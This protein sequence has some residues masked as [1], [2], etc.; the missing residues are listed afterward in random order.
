MAREEL[1]TRAAIVRTDSA[2][3]ALRVGTRVTVTTGKQE[4][5]CSQ[6]QSRAELMGRQKE[7]LWVRLGIQ[8]RENNTRFST[9]GFCRSARANGSKQGA[10]PQNLPCAALPHSPSTHPY[11]SK[12]PAAGVVTL[13]PSQ[14]DLGSSPRFPLHTPWFPAAD[15]PRQADPQLR[16]HRRSRHPL[17]NQYSWTSGD[18]FVPRVPRFHSTVPSPLAAPNRRHR[19]NGHVTA[20][21]LFFTL[22]ASLSR[23][24]FNYC[25]L[26]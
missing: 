21:T 2:G 14:R 15:E 1:W 22:F 6:R 11:P 16:A 4:Q 8:S 18:C 12:L 23:F 25:T 20:H 10:L 5:V 7:Q 13:S 17:P 24:V 19:P 9:A 26:D 3:R